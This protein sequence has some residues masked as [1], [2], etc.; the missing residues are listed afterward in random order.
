MVIALANQ[1]GPL[2]KRKI[3]AGCGV[4]LL[5]MVGAGGLLV[6]KSVSDE[7][8]TRPAVETFHSQFNQD[9]F[10][11]IYEGSNVE[12]RDAVAKQEWVD[13]LA[14]VRRKLGVVTGSSKRTWSTTKTAPKTVFKVVYDTEFTN[15]RAT[16]TFGFVINDD[17][18]SLL[19]YNVASMQLVTR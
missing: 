9:Q 16:E 19:S 11:E 3:A 15:G 17:Q 2:N 18:V 4:L 13:F 14:A 10:V 7:K 8:L 6:Y 5:A 1:D 12:F